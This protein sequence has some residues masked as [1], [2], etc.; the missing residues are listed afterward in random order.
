MRVVRAVRAKRVL[1]AITIVCREIEGLETEFA[2]EV[3]VYSK[4]EG[5][6]VN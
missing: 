5:G 2:K 3:L 1:R 6:S 4:R